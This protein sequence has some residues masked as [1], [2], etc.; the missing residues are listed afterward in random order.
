MNGLHLHTIARTVK[1]RMLPETS[2]PTTQKPAITAATSTSSLRPF[3][4]GLCSSDGAAIWH[5]VD[6]YPLLSPKANNSNMYNT[7]EL[8]RGGVEGDKESR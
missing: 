2:P 8:M 3:R 4:R 5:N 7:S 1:L 6:T